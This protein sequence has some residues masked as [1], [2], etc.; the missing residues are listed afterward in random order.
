MTENVFLIETDFEKAIICRMI[1]DRETVPVARSIIED[2]HDFSMP[3]YGVAYEALLAHYDEGG[4]WKIVPIAERF[5]EA[6]VWELIGESDGFKNIVQYYHTSCDIEDHCRVVRRRALKRRLAATLEIQAQDKSFDVAGLLADIQDVKDELASLEK[7]QTPVSGSQIIRHIIG[8]AASGRIRE[9]AT[10]WKLV[11]NLAR[12]LRTGTVT[13]LAGNIG[14][15]KTFAV[16]QILDKAITDGIPTAALFLEEDIDHYIHR[17][18]AQKAGVAELTNLRFLKENADYAEQLAAEY[19][20]YLDTIRPCINTTPDKLMNHRQ[21]VGWIETQASAGCK[22]IV[23]DPIS[24][25]DDEGQ[26]PW[27]IHKAFIDRVKKIAAA[28]RCAVLLTTHPVKQT[29]LP[30]M[31][32]ISG[33]AAFSRFCQYILWLENHPEKKSDIITDCGTI[34][35]KHDRTLYILKARNAP[36]VFKK[37]AFNFDKDTLTLCEVGLIKKP[38]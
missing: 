14:A 35:L 18:W 37:I 12:P 38:K 15:S 16:L 29:S 26:K 27:I 2:G 4:D 11:N 25:L 30:S 9:I 10:P 19:A 5:A 36:G 7:N 17:F 13:L 8:D 1:L 34:A 6:G 21:C 33:G 20:E 3:E 24:A 31:G 32:E 23:V 22:L 28:Y